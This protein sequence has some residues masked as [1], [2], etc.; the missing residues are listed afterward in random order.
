MRKTKKSDAVCLQSVTV[1]S[2]CPVLPAVPV[3]VPWFLPFFCPS[4]KEMCENTLYSEETS[5]TM[6]SRT[7]CKNKQPESLDSFTR[8][9]AP[10]WGLTL[11]HALPGK[12]QRKYPLRKKTGMLPARWTPAR[13]PEILWHCIP[14]RLL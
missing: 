8:G 5:Y 6:Y 10:Q 13:L 3:S 14:Q 9:A 2:S 11:R 1:I 4:C 12:V 7:F